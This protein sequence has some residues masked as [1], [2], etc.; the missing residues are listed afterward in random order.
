MSHCLV[1]FFTGMQVVTTVKTIGKSLGI[2]HTPHRFVEVYAT[3][4]S[5]PCSISSTVGRSLHGRNGLTSVPTGWRWQCPNR[6]PIYYFLSYF[7]CGCLWFLNSFAK[8]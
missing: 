2:S 5:T 4:K 8:Q 3:V 1:C 7:S 6:L